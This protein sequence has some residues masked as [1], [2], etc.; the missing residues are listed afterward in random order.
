M[1]AHGQITYHNCYSAGYEPLSKKK[2]REKF[3]LEL[4]TDLKRNIDKL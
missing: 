3:H 4:D 2:N 1:R